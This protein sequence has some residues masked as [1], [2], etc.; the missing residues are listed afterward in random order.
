MRL[1]LEIRGNAWVTSA[2]PSCRR[3]PV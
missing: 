1:G 2:V 3:W